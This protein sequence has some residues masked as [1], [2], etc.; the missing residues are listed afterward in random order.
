M[1][2]VQRGLIDRMRCTAQPASGTVLWSVSLPVSREAV[3]T[4]AGLV[5][6]GGVLHGLPLRRDDHGY[7][8]SAPYIGATP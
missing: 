8:A 7:V 6:G 4:D 3:V 2:R 5:Q 1:L